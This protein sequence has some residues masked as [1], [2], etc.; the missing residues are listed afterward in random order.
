MLL[1]SKACIKLKKYMK[2]IG[3][4]I[5]LFFILGGLYSCGNEVKDTEE[6]IEYKASEEELVF[7][8]MV[9]SIDMNDTL[10]TGNSLFYSK[11]NGASIEVKIFVN[12]KGE[13]VKMIE[14]Y[15][16]AGSTSICSNTFYFKKGE[17]IASV[18]KREEGVGEDT[19]FVE[20][21][22]YYDKKDKPFISK[23]RKAEY[24]E[25]LD[26]ESFT[27]IENYDCSLERA[28][29]VLNQSGPFATTFQGFVMEEPFTYLIVGEN[30][31]DGYSSS[32]VV[33]DIDRTIQV[34]SENQ[35]DM[36]GKALIIEFETVGSAEGYEYQI[37]LS[38][39]LR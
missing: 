26:Y 33:Q 37:L 8:D 27:S 31:I 9:A 18:E 4:V 21:V 2:A 29:D 20:R 34:L 15:V 25:E 10:S 19:Y 36:L 6:L 13:T 38:V 30:N 16:D 5:I 39:A 24:E 14:S 35:S 12:E 11:G 23:E 28:L 17:R 32:L 22:S 7:E 3:S 1:L